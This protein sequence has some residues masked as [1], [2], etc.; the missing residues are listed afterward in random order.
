M[1]PFVISRDFL[2]SE[3]SLRVDGKSLKG[4]NKIGDDFV[5]GSD[6]TFAKSLDEIF[7]VFGLEIPKFVSD[8]MRLS[9]E[10]I[11]GDSRIDWMR[12]LGKDRFI[13]HLKSFVTSVEKGFEKFEESKYVETLIEGRR[14]LERL[15]PTLV[16]R[17]EVES[18]LKESDNGFLRSFLP[19]VGNECPPVKYSHDSATGRL[20]VISGPKILNLSKQHR[21][22]MKS[23]F[24]KGTIAM[25]DFV[26]LEPRTALL[27][28]REDTPVDIYEAMRSETKSDLSRA[29]LKVAT[30]ASLYGSTHTDQATMSV[31]ER[32]F[33]VREIHERHLGTS[34]M[35]NL[36][37][38][39]LMPENDRLKLPY[40]VQSTSVD[41]SLI[42]FGKIL[43][44]YLE[45]VPLFVL[46]DALF[47]DV[48]MDLFRELSNTGIEVNV[49]PLGKY[50]LSIQRVD[51]D[52]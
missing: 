37:G 25:I 19:E 45:I 40:F 3:N 11:M 35:V 38:R 2:G 46:H 24:R 10:T 23:R 22:V 29:K 26:S 50:F 47:I 27:L 30:L 18:L 43:R 4:V 15:Q 17:E 13:R 1:K 34:P 31:V 14:L 52:S 28:T 8:E 44:K 21:R 33:R 12:A 32:F 16:D 42:G 20:R 5:I 36:Y 7:P 41:V 9:Y 39:P 49:E 51:Q 6:A 48:E